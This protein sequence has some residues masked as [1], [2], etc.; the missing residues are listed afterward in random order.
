MTL[1]CSRI[2]KE[3]AMMSGFFRRRKQAEVALFLQVTRIR[4]IR[5]ICEANTV[6]LFLWGLVILTQMILKTV[7]KRKV[8]TVADWS[9]WICRFIMN[10][11]FSHPYWLRKIAFHN[12][13]F[14]D[15]F[16]NTELMVVLLLGL[17]ISVKQ[18]VEYGSNFLTKGTKTLG[19]RFL[20]WQVKFLESWPEIVLLL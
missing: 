12:I 18:T 8:N 5:K 9:F 2:E 19:H 13:F 6:K 17:C 11:P 15:F 3:I 7:Y 10:S 4:N 16:I 14:N 20:I 1:H